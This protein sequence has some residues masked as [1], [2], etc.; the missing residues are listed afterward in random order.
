M[1]LD[2]PKTR[3]DISDS[4]D[5]SFLKTRFDLPDP[6]PMSHC[7]DKCRISG[8]TLVK[9]EGSRKFMF[10][11][12]TLIYMVGI[13]FG[14]VCQWR[15]G[16]EWRGWRSTHSPARRLLHAPQPDAGPPGTVGP[17]SLGHFYIVSRYIKMNTSRKYN[18]IVKAWSNTIWGARLLLLYR[19]LSFLQ[20]N[21]DVLQ[22]RGHQH[23]KQWKV[24]VKK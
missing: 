3:S 22:V 21:H 19:L 15:G 20:H 4:P 6:Q 1:V 11:V 23:L 14:L 10:S 12:D 16:Q 18:K 17:R 7:L 8:E 24:A 2:G 13:T 9:Q 5:Q